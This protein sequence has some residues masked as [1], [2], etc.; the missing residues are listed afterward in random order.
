[1]KEFT[2]VFHSAQ[3]LTEFVSVSNRQNFDVLLICGGAELNAKSIMRLFGVP[4]EQPVTVRI[5]AG[6][7]D[8]AFHSFRPAYAM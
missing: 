7:N 4:M 2:V 5:P 3:E 1:M 8:A 6:A